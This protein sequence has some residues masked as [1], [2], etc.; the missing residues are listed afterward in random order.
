[1]IGF[2]ASG[3]TAN[4]HLLAEKMNI[5][6]V[7]TDAVISD[8]EQL[9]IPEIFA[10]KGEEY[11]RELETN[12]LQKIIETKESQVISTGGGLVVNDNNK[13]LLKSKTLVVWMYASPEEIVKRLKP[14][15]RPLLDVE[16]PLEKAQELFALRRTHYAKIADIIINTE[17]GLKDKISQ[18]IYEEINTTFYD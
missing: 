11:F 14:G 7:D 1:M 9:T 5:S 12:T 16:N 18:K 4:S 6:C 3:K 13:K 8:D 17:F 15:K 2:M 10:T